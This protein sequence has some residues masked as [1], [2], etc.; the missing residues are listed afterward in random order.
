MDRKK[1]SILQ[2]PWTMVRFR[3]DEH[4]FEIKGERV[5]R[6]YHLINTKTDEGIDRLLGYLDR[7]GIDERLKEAGAHT[8]DT[9]ILD[10]Y[11]F[12][13]YE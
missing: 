1:R 8:G 2:K 3:N 6:T 4:T 10:D 7:I 12:D 9:V 5:V 13:Y 11:E